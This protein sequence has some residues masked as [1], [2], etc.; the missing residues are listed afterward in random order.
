MLQGYSYALTRLWF[1]CVDVL[2][3]QLLCAFAMEWEN[4][5]KDKKRKEV[6]E[7]EKGDA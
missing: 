1:M 5:K 4:I 2:S 6:E 7:T 3:A